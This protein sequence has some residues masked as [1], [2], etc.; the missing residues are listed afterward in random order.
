MIQLTKLN[1][2]KFY[3]NCELIEIIEEMPDTLITMTT[4]KK[5]YAQET[6]AEVIAKIHEFK[7]MFYANCSFIRKHRNKPEVVEKPQVD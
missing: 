1:N 6:A 3:L 7:M 4:G 5:H 2:E